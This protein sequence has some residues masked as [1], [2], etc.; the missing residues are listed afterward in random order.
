MEDEGTSVDLDRCIG[1]GA[2]SV[3]CP[4]G[5]IALEAKDKVYTPPKH[6]DAMY[7]KILVERIGVSGMLKTIPKMI[8]KRKI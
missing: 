6:H 8:L 7:Q 5:A 2:C 4:S 1:C 3:A